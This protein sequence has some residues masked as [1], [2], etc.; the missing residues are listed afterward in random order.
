MTPGQLDPAIVRRRLMALDEALQILRRHQSAT[1]ADLRSVRE[2]LWVVERGL[3]LAAQNALDIAT[4]VAA[5]AG[6]DTP[7]Y[8]SA[9]DALAEL[10][11]LPAE[12]VARFRSIAGF[13]NVLVHGYLELD[14]EEVVSLLQDRLE[15]FVTFAGGIEAY[16]LGQDGER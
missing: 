9:I 15:E 8:R 16:L 3:Q 11:I 12:F 2:R 4:H 7:D 13:R 5:A 6:R 10:G 14:L 1:A